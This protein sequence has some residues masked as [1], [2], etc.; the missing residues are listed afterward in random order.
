[1]TSPGGLAGGV[2]GGDLTTPAGPPGSGSVPPAEH[3][4]RIARSTAAM[5]V[6][7]AVSR[8]TGF[9]LVVV[10]AAVLGTTYL[11]NTYESANTVPNLLFELVAAGALQAVL[12]PTLVVHLDR[13]DQRGAEHVAGAVL[14]IA[15]LGMAIV[16]LVGVVLAPVLARVLFAGVADADVRADEVRLG[17]VFLW[18]FLPQIVLYTGGLVATSV[19]N[20]RDRFIVPVV[21]PIAN[22]VIVLATC[23]VFWLMTRGTA[24]T[25]DLSAAEVAVLAG[26][27]TL[28]VIAF[29]GLPFAAAVR[30]GFRLRPNLDHR[31]AEVRRLGRLGWWAGVFLAVQQVL[32]VVVLLLANRV[33]GGVVAYQVAFKFFLL[34]YALFGLPLM[35]AYFPTMSRQVGERDWGGYAQAI[36]RGFR[37]MAYFLLPAAAALTALAPLLARSVLFGQTGE[38]GAAQVAG[39]LA[40]L[41]PGAFGYASVLFLSRTLY[42]RA[43][44]RTPALVNIGIAIG[45]SVLMVIG[46]TAMDGTLRVPALA[47]AHSVAFTVGAVVLHHLATNRIP[48]GRRPRTGRAIAPSLAAAVAAGAAMWGAVELIDPQGRG[49]SIVV[50]L[51]VG[52]VGLVLYAGLAAVLGGPRPAS[53]VALLRGRDG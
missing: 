39:V 19:L 30:G 17:T 18:F 22:N 25:L 3:E 15:C 40:G 42:A 11:G 5:T 32:L 35:T 36:E 31:H 2:S 24:P 26:G 7:T 10:V 47:V 37:A 43:D 53:V 45:G 52:A 28:G 29:C 49:A 20:A 9:V 34:P 1:M 4:V 12:I 41:A 23:V 51:V 33:A 50:M 44:T 27:T 48:D 21:A 14:G 6:L 46:F 38:S 8:L 16:A 13:D